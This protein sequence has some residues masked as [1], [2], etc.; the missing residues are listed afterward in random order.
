MRSGKE[1][2]RTFGD[3]ARFFEEQQREDDSDPDAA[4]R[5][6]TPE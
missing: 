4:D 1:P 3:L 6:D 2:M 5:P